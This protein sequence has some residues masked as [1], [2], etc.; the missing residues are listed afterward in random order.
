MISTVVGEKFNWIPIKFVESL[1]PQYRPDKMDGIGD[2]VL[3]VVL[4]AVVDEFVLGGGVVLLLVVDAGV[5]VAVDVD[6]RTEVVGN[7]VDCVGAT[8]VLT[9]AVGARLV[10]F[11]ALE[12]RQ[13][14]G[15]SCGQDGSFGLKHIAVELADFQ[16]NPKQTD[17][18]NQNLQY[19]E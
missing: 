13:R 6:V 10:E 2:T 18:F 9:D 5:V 15:S 7:D 3:V 11:R 8:D 19:E 12:S 14:T 16:Y 1:L 4:V 17:L